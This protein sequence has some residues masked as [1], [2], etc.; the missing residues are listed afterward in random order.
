M[1]ALDDIGHLCQL[2]RLG[3]PMNGI[4]YATL[5]PKRWMIKIFF[6]DYE[7]LADFE[8]L[9][10]YQ[11]YLDRLAQHTKGIELDIRYIDA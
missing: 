5:K 2:S 9:I 6:A 7:D 4:H 10:R 3:N 8:R 11:G 1:R